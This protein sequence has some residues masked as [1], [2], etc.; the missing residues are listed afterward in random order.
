MKGAAAS[1][2]GGGLDLRRPRSASNL[3]RRKKTVIPKR[4]EGS[5][6]NAAPG[7][8]WRPAAAEPFANAFRSC[9][10][11]YAVILSAAKDLPQTP[12]LVLG[13]G[14]FQAGPLPLACFFFA[15]T[16]SC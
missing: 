9:L 11:R 4:S 2:Q 6:S 12:S 3:A 14:Q 8:A 15:V 7:F 10:C 5:A 1:A 13:N 16:P